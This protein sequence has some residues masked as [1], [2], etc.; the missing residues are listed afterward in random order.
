MSASPRHEW[1]GRRVLVTGATGIVGS[2]LVSELLEQGAAVIGLVC[3]VDPAAAIVRSGN[4]QR[5]TCVYGRLEDGAA[6]GRAVGTWEPDTVIHLG[7]QTLVGSAARA[8][9]ATFEANIRGTYQLLEACRAHQG[10]IRSIVVASSDKAYGSSPSLPYTEATP[11]RAVHPYDVSKACA[12]LIAL[13]YAETYAMPVTVARCGNI[14]GGGDL[15]WSRLVP[16]TI[17]SLLCGE[18]PVIRS[19]GQF[20]RD[21]LYVKDAV[22]AYLRLAAMTGPSLRGEA[23]NFSGDARRTVLEVVAEIQQ[24]MRRMDLEPDIRNEARAEIREQW[25]SA[26]KA[27]DQLDWRPR[28]SLDQGLRETIEWYEQWLAERGS[29]VYARGATT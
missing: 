20:V 2:W 25:L 27:A 26:E 14:Y 12:D 24:L 9:L 21:Y 5:I 1:Q 8:P 29:P 22:S 13:A 10:L 7:A 17:R 15:N 19:D 4:L 16:G 28:Y 11:L 3:D 6:V 23:F 18:R